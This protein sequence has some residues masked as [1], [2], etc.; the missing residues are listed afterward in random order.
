MPCLCLTQA[1]N[2]RA[3]LLFC[4]NILRIQGIADP[5]TNARMRNSLRDYAGVENRTC[6]LL[7][8]ARFVNFSY[9]C[10]RL[11]AYSCRLLRAKL[12]HRTAPGIKRTKALRIAMTE[13]QEDLWSFN[14]FKLFAAV[15]AQMEGSR[16]VF[17]DVSVNRYCM[18]R[19]VRLGLKEREIN[20][21]KI[22]IKLLFIE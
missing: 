15:H 4:Q 2:E 17:Q 9:S 6:K 8:Q 16:D 5:K 13:F 21:N 11:L 1:A 20:R 12:L 3:S 19:Y 14:S 10:C 7:L 22:F 18:K